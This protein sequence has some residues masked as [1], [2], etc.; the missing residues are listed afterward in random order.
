MIYLKDLGDVD[1]VTCYRIQVKFTINVLKL[2]MRIL[3]AGIKLT[4]DIFLF[5][6]NEHIVK[7][8]IYCRYKTEW[9]MPTHQL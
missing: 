8:Y 7:M 5:Y 6:K 2:H 1:V 9:C 3:F 4:F